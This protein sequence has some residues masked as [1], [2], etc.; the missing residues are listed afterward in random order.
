MSSAII[1]VSR[2]MN[3][4]STVIDLADALPKESWMLIGG[5]MTQ[6]HAMAVGHSSRATADVDLLVDVMASDSHVSAVINQLK[7]MGFEPK[8]PGLR[9]SAFHRMVKGEL[10]ADVLVADHLPKSRTAVTKL[11][12]WPIMEVP[13]G[14][15]AIERKMNLVLRHEDGES[16]LQTP[17]LLGVLVLKAAAYCADRRDRHRHLDDVALLA[18]LIEDHKSCISRLHGSDKKRLRAVAKALN[19]AEDSSWRKLNL[20]NRKKGQLTLRILSA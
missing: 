18:S 20:E 10:I 6:A 2:T 1:E 5:L 8:E 3:P 16:V 12:R 9:G 7:M 4:W 15:Q 17:D 13:G 11:N 14:A 19:D